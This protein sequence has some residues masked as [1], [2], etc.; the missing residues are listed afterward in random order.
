M[1]PMIYILED[2]PILGRVTTATVE[3]LGYETRLD[4][5]GNQLEGWLA[6]D[7][8]PAALLLDVH[9]PLANGLEI[10]AALRAD[11]RLAALPRIMMTADIQKANRLEEAGET[12]LLKPVGVARLQSALRHALGEA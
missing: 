2:D 4:A 12:V 3:Q 5:D 1:T 6:N 7:P 11:P 10:V 9:M 8:L